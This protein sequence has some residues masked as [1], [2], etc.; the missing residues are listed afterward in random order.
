MGSRVRT[1]VMS[2]E[3]HSGIMPHNGKQGKASPTARWNSTLLADCGRAPGGRSAVS[4]R[5]KQWGVRGAY[6]VGIEGEM[7]Y[8]GAQS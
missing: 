6:V 7:C 4:A 5:G 2:A 8:H 1:P 3:Q